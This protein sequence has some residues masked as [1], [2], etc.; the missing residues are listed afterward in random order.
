MLVPSR[1]GERRFT[2]AAQARMA[3]VQGA[4]ALKGE[5]AEHRAKRRLGL[6]PQAKRSPR[7]APKRG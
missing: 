7:S 3:L 5:F 1:A 4:T 6:A 2:W